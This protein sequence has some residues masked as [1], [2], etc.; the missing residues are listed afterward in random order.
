MAT[1]KRRYK[2]HIG[3]EI[4]DLDQDWDQTITRRVWNIECNIEFFERERERL[5]FLKCL[6]QK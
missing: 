3:A 1:I 2:R 6:N 5:S 4:E